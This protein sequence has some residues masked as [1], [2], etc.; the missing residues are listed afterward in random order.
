MRAL[1]F[2][3]VGGQ[4]MYGHADSRFVAS[5]TGR[6][7]VLQRGTTTDLLRYNKQTL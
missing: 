7:K 6:G 2:V 1:S 5:S 3:A 4:R